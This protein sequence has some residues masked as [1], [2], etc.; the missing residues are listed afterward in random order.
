M[1]VGLLALIIILIFF[2]NNVMKKT[3]KGAIN[4]I[5]TAATVYS[6]SNATWLLRIRNSRDANI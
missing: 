5:W 2:K 3:K 1:T 6:Q 4:N